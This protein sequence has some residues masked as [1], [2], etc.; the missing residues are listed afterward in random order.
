VLGYL[1]A[2]AVKIGGE[3]AVEKAKI[4]SSLENHETREAIEILE[5]MSTAVEILEMLGQEGAVTPRLESISV[6]AAAL[7]EELKNSATRMTGEE[8]VGILGE[9]IKTAI[10]LLEKIAE[11]A[12][13]AQSVGP[14][15]AEAAQE[16]IDSAQTVINSVIE[17]LE[18][19]LAPTLIKAAETGLAALDFSA[20]LHRIENVELS[21]V[22]AISFS[23]SIKTTKENSDEKTESDSE[24]ED[25]LSEMADL[26]IMRREEPDDYVQLAG[27]AGEEIVEN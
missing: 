6:R 4:A 3:N 21:I 11:I 1:T 13:Q 26:L 19:I 10:P 7:I 14:R 15:A 25:E 24:T 17:E 5:L 12:S 18:S 8:A 22:K 23:E 9:V 16:I 2:L 27:K 20:M